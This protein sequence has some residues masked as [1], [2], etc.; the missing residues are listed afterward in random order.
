MAIPTV[1]TSS[2]EAEVGHFSRF[3]IARS[4]ISHLELV[5]SECPGGETV[6]RGGVTGTADAHAWAL[7]VDFAW[8]HARW[9][10]PMSA[11]SLGDARVVPAAVTEAAEWAN[12]RLHTRSVHL[13]SR[14]KPDS[15]ANS[16]VAREPAGFRLGPGHED[17][18]SL[19]EPSRRTP[20]WRVRNPER[21]MCSPRATRATR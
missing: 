18:G 10:S 13:R 16:A 8:H 15:L 7:L 11:A 19:A 5:P 3:P 14:D 6:L 4:F 12:G 9:R 2:V 1:T 17:A 20:R 21:T